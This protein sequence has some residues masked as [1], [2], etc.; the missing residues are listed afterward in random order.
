MTR[1]LTTGEI[2]AIHGQVMAQ[3][4]GLVG[5]RDLAALESAAAQ[6]Q[7]TFGGAELYPSLVEKAAAISF[8]LIQNHP[9]IDGNKRIGHAAVELF[10]ILNGYEI[11]A[12]IDDQ[13][14]VIL[15][16]ASSTITR[17]ELADWMQHHLKAR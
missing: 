5:L 6:P 4:G 17:A 16:V 3:S 11:V 13:E 12:D 7:A 2:I 14:H 1:Y 8:S 9:F 15:G 10:L